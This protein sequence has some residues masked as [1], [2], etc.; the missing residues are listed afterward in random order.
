MASAFTVKANRA[1]GDA[2]AGSALAGES[3]ETTTTK[4]L[5]AKKLI[6]RQKM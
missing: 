6:L 1:P 3:G 4:M 5:Y 2:L